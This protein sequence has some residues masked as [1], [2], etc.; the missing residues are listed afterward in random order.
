MK[1]V[2]VFVPTWNSEKTL[3][4]SLKAIKKAV[5]N[6]KIVIFDNFSSDKTLDIARAYNAKVVQSKGNLGETRQLM[7]EMASDDFLMIDSDI[8]LTE[9]WFRDILEFVEEL[10]DEKLGCVQGLTVPLYE[11]YRSW[12]VLQQKKLG[13]PLKNKGRLLTTNVFLKKEAVKGFKCTLPVLEDYLLGKHIEKKGFNW[14]VT[15]KAHAHHDCYRDLKDIARHAKW[16]GAGNAMAG[17][18]PFWKYGLGIFYSGLVKAPR[19]YKLFSMRLHWYCFIGG[20]NFR[21]YLTLKR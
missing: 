19:P 5:S 9:S 7:C 12:W 3:E 4:K 16:L 6:S 2:E 17:R 13:F 10:G 20:L 15:K 1:Q 14:Y 11:P 18:Y 21:R 8:Y